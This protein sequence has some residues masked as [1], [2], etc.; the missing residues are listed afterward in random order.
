MILLLFEAI[1]SNWSRYANKLLPLKF[2]MQ[3]RRNKEK[4]YFRFWWFY[5]SVNSLVFVSIGKIYQTHE[6]LFYRL[7][8]YFEFRQ[9]YSAA[10]RIFNSLLG[11]WIS[12]WNTLVFDL[13]LEQLISIHQCYDQPILHDLFESGEFAFRCDHVSHENL[14]LPC[15][16]IRLL[17]LCL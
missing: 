2:L 3:R 7:S 12:R 16:A 5:L 11:V 17:E 1:S 6:T 13:L 10:R 15:R 9:K 14:V 8:K 4:L